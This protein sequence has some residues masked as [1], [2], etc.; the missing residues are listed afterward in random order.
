MRNIK[1]MA[2]PFKVNEFQDITDKLMRNDLGKWEP[3]RTPE[4]ITHLSIHHS[5]V[6]GATIESYAR[7]HVGTNKWRSIGYHLVIK[8]DQV[9]QVNNLLA[10]SYHTSSNNG[11]TIGIS[12]SADLSKRPLS[13]IERLNLYAAIL[14]V[15]DLFK[16]PVENVLGH[17]QYPDNKTSCP[18]I[19]M[20]KVRDDISKLILSIKV[21]ESPEQILSNLFKNVNQHIYLYN[22]YKADP[23][24]Q[25]WLEPYLIK[26]HQITVDMKMYFN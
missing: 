6:E 24:G 5:A 22:Q 14:T 25:K 10:F 11:Y 16:I 3:D 26:L 21:A 1:V 13:E 19:N 9:F 12:I 4:Q 17:N 18:C 20:N 23:L 2:L 15:M 7:Y 8:G